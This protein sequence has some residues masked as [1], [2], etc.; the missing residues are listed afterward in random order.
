MAA[1][2]ADLPSASQPPLARQLIPLVA[3]LPFAAERAD[4]FAKVW[5][6]IN[7]AQRFRLP[8]DRFVYVH[9]AG[10]DDMSFR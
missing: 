7:D 4:A 9:G 2:I 10:A 5:V 1:H 8:L 3:K 6:S